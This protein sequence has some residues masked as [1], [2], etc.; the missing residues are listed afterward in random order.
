MIEI[1]C[2][3]TSFSIC[4]KRSFNTDTHTR[5]HTHTYV[6]AGCKK[7]QRSPRSW[8]KKKKNQTNANPTFPRPLNSPENRPI[9]YPPYLDDCAKDK[10]STFLCVDSYKHT[11]CS[12]YRARTPCKFSSSAEADY[13]AL[14][15]TLQ[16]CF[17]PPCFQYL[18]VSL[19][20]FVISIPNSS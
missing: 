8:H 18:T 3:C 11:S 19:S 9:L 10:C 7:N 15:S 2:H 6:S 16:R 1:G 4:S 20:L 17:F 13:I 14:M 5:R 12:S